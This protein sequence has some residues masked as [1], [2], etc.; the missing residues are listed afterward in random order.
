[1]RGGLC[2]LAMSIGMT[3]AALA[4]G[5]LF[6]EGGGAANQDALKLFAAAVPGDKLVCFIITA[7]PT[8][9]AGGGWL[10]S[11]GLNPAVVLVTTD[12]AADPAISKTL[13]VCDG[14][15]FDGGAPALLSEAFLKDGKDTPALATIRRRNRDGAPIG[16]SSAGAMIL[17]PSTM[18]ACGMH[19]GIKALAGEAVP[20]SPA[21]AFLPVP[22]DAHALTQNLYSRELF[23]M[24][25]ENWQRLLVLDESATVEIP[26]DGSPWKVIGPRTV[27]LLKAPPKD[28]KS[29]AD[30][31]ISFLHQNDTIDPVS[32][33]A[34]TKG[35]KALPPP[36]WGWTAEAL[37]M[38]PSA[39][40]IMATNLAGGNADAYFWD[41]FW[42]PDK[43]V[44]LHLKWTEASAGF[45]NPASADKAQSL[46]THLSLTI[47][48][49]SRAAYKVAVTVPFDQR[50]AERDWHIAP[51]DGPHL[52]CNLDSPTPTTAPG[53]TVYSHDAVVAALADKHTL[54][55]NV[56][57][58]PAPMTVIPGSRW[59]S[60]PGNCRAGSKDLD[61]HF[62]ERLRVLTDG[63]RS[64]PLVF[65]CAHA[66][67]WWSYNA[68]VR[69]RALGY[70]AVG[71]YRGG[72]LDWENY[73]GE[74]GKTR[75]DQW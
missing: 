53:V 44:R 30:F 54:V 38:P 42:Y 2:A 40:Q 58:G 52:D 62:A 66:A 27:M 64:R 18:C 57:P 7:N 41:T 36:H 25:Q 29:L 73:E 26:G 68:A 59:L 71:W 14:Y 13:A 35:R 5:P 16:G 22:L 10:K 55:F 19:I 28:A 50:I 31:D 17:G 60:G 56:L 47:E 6:A 67:C 69:A 72:L 11:A 34:I 9:K 51:L 24:G 43:P 39:L 32:F 45:E 37:Q 1:M 65:Y 63:D 15:Y 21:F 48:R 74:T 33:E 61:A 46:L 4:A 12:N 20:L 3:G 75:Q 23:V 8:N 49:P 70:T